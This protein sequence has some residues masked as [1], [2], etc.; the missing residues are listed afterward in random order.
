MRIEEKK[1]FVIIGVAIALVVAV[2]A[3]L[4][5][6]NTTDDPGIP[7]YSTASKEVSNKALLIYKKNE[8][9]NCHTLWTQRN[10]MQTVPAP[11]LDGIGSIRTETFFYEYLSAEDP[12]LILPS[13][14]KKEFQMP[15]YAHLL[16]DDRKILA[17]YMASL[18]VKDWYLEETRKR[19]YEK[20]TGKKYNP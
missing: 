16:D 4:G 13:R 7:F 3:I 10:I 19:E 1:I 14:L 8:C 5:H 6:Y 9:K 2:K 18:K 11:P 12:Q 15:S 17:A 20:L